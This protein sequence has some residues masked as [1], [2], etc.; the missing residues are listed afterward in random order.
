MSHHAILHDFD[1]YEGTLRA[2]AEA[3]RARV[4]QWLAAETSLKVH[5]VTARVKSRESLE[6]KLARPDKSYGALWDVTDL[7]GLRVITYFEDDVDRVGRIIEERLAVRFADSVDKRHRRDAGAFGYRSLHYVFGLRDG[8]DSPLPAEARCELQA[9]SV[10][11][12]AWAEIEHDL[13]YKSQDAV[14]LAVRRRLHRLAGLLE[15]AD[16]E[17]VAIRRDL[18]DYAR[19][20][21]QRLAGDDDVPLDLVSLPLLLEHGEIRDADRAVAR[22]LSMELGDALFYPDYLL[23]LL[24]HGGITTVDAARR[25]VAARRK[26]LEAMVSPYFEF[27]SREWKLSPKES[28]GVLR[29]Y[30]LFFLAH[31]VVLEAPSLGIDK[32]ER[33]TRLYRELDYPEDERAA[34]HVASRLVDAFAALP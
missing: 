24:A 15:L 14:P 32:V 7:V 20:L 1:R 21:P 31:A 22:A 4:S 5:S 9:R 10:L 33:L 12:H 11:D 30:S 28:G 8:D 13:G 3:L 27:A 26:T 29:G 25:G 6:G 17:F 18:E 2:R 19:A 16:Q 34:Q 23:R